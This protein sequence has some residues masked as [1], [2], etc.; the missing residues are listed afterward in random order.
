MKLRNLGIAAAISLIFGIAYAVADAPQESTSTTPAATEVPAAAPAVGADGFALPP[1]KKAM[2]EAPPPPADA[3]SPL[4][5]VKMTPVGQLKNPYAKNP[6]MA[7]WGQK[8]YMGNSCNG[9]HGGTG[10]GGMCPPI[11]N[12]TW[13]YGSDDDTLFRLIVLGSDELQKQ[14]GVARKGREN[15]VGPMPAFGGIIKTDDEVWR[16]ISF[17]RTTYRGDPSRVNW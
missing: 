14:L 16:I 9:C 3:M 8:R 4:E 1:Q 5:R 6:D 15:V 17:L 12:E 2:G 10:G 11:S 7:K 13:V